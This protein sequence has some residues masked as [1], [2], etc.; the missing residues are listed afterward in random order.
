[1]LFVAQ[2]HTQIQ[3]LGSK[4]AASIL[5]KQR[6]LTNNTQFW[7]GKFSGN[8]YPVHERL[9]ILMPLNLF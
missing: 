5:H 7:N 4:I 3:I 9:N 1:M 6:H 2:S 8:S